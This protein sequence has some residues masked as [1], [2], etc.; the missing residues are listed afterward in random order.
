MPTLIARWTCEQDESAELPSFFRWSG[1]RPATLDDY[2]KHCTDTYELES[3]DAGVEQRIY[4]DIVADVRY[5]AFGRSWFVTGQ[6]I[7]SVSLQ[8]PDPDATDQEISASLRD[9]PRLYRAVIHRG[10][11]SEKD[12]VVP[13]PFPVTSAIEENILTG[14]RKKYGFPVVRITPNDVVSYCMK[15][16]QNPSVQDAVLWLSRNRSDLEDAMR[17]AVERDLDWIFDDITLD[18]SPDPAVNEQLAILESLIFGAAD[19]YAS[20]N[21]CNDYGSS[22]DSDELLQVVAYLVESP[23]DRK[24]CIEYGYE[25]GPPFKSLEEQGD[26]THRTER[27][28]IIRENGNLTVELIQSPKCGHD[29]SF[30]VPHSSEP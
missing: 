8:L 21:G 9:L 12:T 17:I 3:T 28:H 5:D 16:R 26:A 22:V 29:S 15:H 19:R 6:G 20:E 1:G 24:V 30:F 11:C 10:S 13:T 25:F 7:E 2:F 27:I 4:P 14:G 18:N 23:A